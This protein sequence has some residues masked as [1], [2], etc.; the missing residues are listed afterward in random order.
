[1]SGAAR[2]AARV[3]GLLLAALALAGCP[4]S[5][6]SMRVPLGREFTLAPGQSVVVGE[7]GLRVTLGGV[8]GD[9]RCPSDVQCVWEGD[10]TVTLEVASGS[11]PAASYELHTSGRFAREAMHLAYRVTLVRLDPVPRGAAPVAPSD[12][13]ATLAVVP[14]ASR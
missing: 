14:L 6:S 2:T 8:A 4:S 9:S 1:V 12:Y 3:L 13:R 7:A 5:P 10:A 11:T